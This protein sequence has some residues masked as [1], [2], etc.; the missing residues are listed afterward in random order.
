MEYP[1][2]STKVKVTTQLPDARWHKCIS[3]F[4]RIAVCQTQLRKRGI[5]WGYTASFQV[6]KDK[7]KR[8]FPEF[9]YSGLFCSFFD[10]LTKASDLNPIR[11]EWSPVFHD[12]PESSVY[13]SFS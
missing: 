9:T 13:L 3:I 11:T 6:A 8:S 4:A 1:A 7:S 10:V 2:P 5:E 12:V